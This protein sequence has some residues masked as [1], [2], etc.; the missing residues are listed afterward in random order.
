MGVRSLLSACLWSLLMSSTFPLLFFPRSPRATCRAKD[1]LDRD[2]YSNPGPI[3]FHGP[4]ADDV[5]FTLS[6]SQNDY[7][8]RI[9]S[10]RAKLA[11]VLDI[12]RPGVSDGL[13]DAAL[14]GMTSLTRI[15]AVMKERE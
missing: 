3:Q 4:S 8:E 7:M 13:L 15:L 6:S 12:C 5:T 9:A 14:T 10:L 11:D 1:W 2:V